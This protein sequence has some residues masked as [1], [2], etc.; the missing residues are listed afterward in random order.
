VHD[1]LLTQLLGEMD[2]LQTG[3]G[4][5]KADGVAVVGTPYKLNPAAP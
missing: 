3:G 1:R 2:C 5:G 4:G